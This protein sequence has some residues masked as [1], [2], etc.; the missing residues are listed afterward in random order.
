MKSFKSNFGEIASTLEKLATPEG[1]ALQE[2]ILNLDFVM[3]YLFMSDVMSHLTSCSKIMQQGHALPWVYPETVDWT[4]DTLASMKDGPILTN[5]QN[6][7]PLNQGLFP[8]FF[9]CPE[10]VTSKQYNGCPLLNILIS[11]V[12]AELQPIPK[13]L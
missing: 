3:D 1:N 11:T 10:I 6:N 2:T 9:Q 8:D 13:I 7:G 5:L 4:L 12:G